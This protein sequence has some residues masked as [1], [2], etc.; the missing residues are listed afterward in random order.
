MI[1]HHFL[2]STRQEQKK[3]RAALRSHPPAVA[4]E[5]FLGYQREVQALGDARLANMVLSMY[6]GHLLFDA[7]CFSTPCD[8][9]DKPM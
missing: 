1:I 5:L 7:A 2:G 9:H 8:F 3:L 4:A 6:Q